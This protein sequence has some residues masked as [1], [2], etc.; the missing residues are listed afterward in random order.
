M[1]PKKYFSMKMHIQTFL[2]E[3]FIVSLPQLG[4]EG[5]NYETTFQLTVCSGVSCC[6]QSARSTAQFGRAYLNGAR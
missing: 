4:E 6:L 5:I 3:Q 2:G 1:D